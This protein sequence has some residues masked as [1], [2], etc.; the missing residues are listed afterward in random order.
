MSKNHIYEN[1]D[2][3]GIQIRFVPSFPSKIL[4]KNR[5]PFNSKE[6]FEGHSVYSYSKIGSI[7]YCIIALLKLHL[8]RISKIKQSM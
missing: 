2:V 3:I 4:L 6:K 8:K 1:F 7:D 5:P